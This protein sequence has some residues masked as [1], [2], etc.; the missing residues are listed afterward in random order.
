MER[1]HPQRH[2]IVFDPEEHLRQTRAIAKN[3]MKK[4]RRVKRKSLLCVKSLDFGNI[5][6]FDPKSH[7]RPEEIVSNVLTKIRHNHKI[8]VYENNNKNDQNDNEID[9]TNERFKITAKFFCDIIKEYAVNYIYQYRLGVTRAIFKNLHD[10]WSEEFLPDVYQTEVYSLKFYSEIEKMLIRVVL[11]NLEK[12][13][14]E[15]V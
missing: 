9:E 7:I 8:V 1:P 13:D 3:K 11:N 5:I 12:L 4:Q 10:L 6:P 15:F 2:M 14:W